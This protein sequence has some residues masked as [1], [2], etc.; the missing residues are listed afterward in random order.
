ML[1][2]FFA[3]FGVLHSRFAE[4][5]PVFVRRLFVRDAKTNDHPGIGR[6]GHLTEIR[7]YQAAGCVAGSVAVA[8]GSVAWAPSAACCA[9]AA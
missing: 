3:L 2:G 5:N 6:D 9:S 1:S 7:E 8:A 4:K